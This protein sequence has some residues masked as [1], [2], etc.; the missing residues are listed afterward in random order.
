MNNTEIDN[1][2]QRFATLCQQHPDIPLFMQHWWMSAVCAGKH[3]DVCIYTDKDGKDIAAMPYLHGKHC[4]MRYILMPQQTQIGGVWID[5]DYKDNTE[6]L[7][8]ITHFFAQHIEQLQ[9]AYYYQQYPIESPLPAL[10][11]EHHFKLKKRITYRI[12][13]LDNLNDVI[14]RFSK[15]KKR[16]LQKALAL[17]PD[18]N[19]NPEDFYRFHTTCLLERKKQ[20]SYTRE[21]FLVMYHKAILHEQ[22]QIIAIRDA[23]NQLLAAA[24]LVWDKR[25]LYYLIPCYTQTHKDS[26]AG[27]LLV[28]EALKIAR[29]RG[30]QFD[31]EGS[32]IRGVANHYRQFGSTPYTYYAVSRM[33]NPLFAIL[34]LANRIRTRK[35]Q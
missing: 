23:D 35:K 9:L 21:F 11:K 6:I 2:K 28:L 10:L 30:K 29:E 17:H 27:A 3:W 20:I 22:G 24:F 15:N 18:Y 7:Q 25:S 34:L 8:Q 12:E 4:G 5:P 19:L 16:Q 13:D 33:R 14:N 26:G 31:F 32:M 1:N